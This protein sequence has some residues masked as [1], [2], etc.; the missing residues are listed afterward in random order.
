MGH[1][2]MERIEQDMKLVGSNEE[3]ISS[4]IIHVTATTQSI[5]RN[6]RRTCWESSV[7][8]PNIRIRA[9]RFVLCIQSYA[10]FRQVQARHW[11]L[12]G[13]ALLCNTEA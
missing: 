2:W 9:N 3:I 5:Y 8:V 6:I 12:R 11:I 13:V 1:I 4:P 7:R 10:A